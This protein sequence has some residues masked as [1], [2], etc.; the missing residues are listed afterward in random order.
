MLAIFV[1]GEQCL[2]DIPVIGIS[3]NSQSRKLIP[4][5]SYSVAICHPSS[6]QTLP[7]KIFLHPRK[8]TLDTKNPI[9]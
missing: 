3:W 2:E 1:F 7:I 8:L 4:P 6:E 5:K 9:L